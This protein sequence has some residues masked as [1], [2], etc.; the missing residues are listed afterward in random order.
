MT[1]KPVKETT[2]VLDANIPTLVL[3]SEQQ[4]PESE[5]EP[6]R[7]LVVKQVEFD[8]IK[9]ASLDTLLESVE[10]EGQENKKIIVDIADDEYSFEELLANLDKVK[11]VT[12]EPKLMLEEKAEKPELFCF[13][14]GPFQSSDK[15][16]QAIQYFESSEILYQ[17]RS[18]E[19]KQYIGMLVYLPSHAS[20]EVVIQVA[21]SLSNKGV[22]DYMLLNEPGKSNALSLGVYGLKKNAETRKSVLAKL[23]YK[24]ETEARYR[25]KAVQWLD[26]EIKNVDGQ[27]EAVEQQITLLKASQIKRSCKS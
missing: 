19:E 14:A 23:G 8:E 11:S 15:I 27:I 2:I 20:R 26:Y 7:E 21:E 4:E 1:A 24:A 9:Q 6:E 18:S 17:Q 3:L 16:Q 22:S 5:P 10:K 25:T 12:K 13:T